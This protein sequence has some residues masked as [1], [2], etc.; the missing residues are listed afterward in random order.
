MSCYGDQAHCE[1]INCFGQ[2][3]IG[4]AGLEIRI[5]ALT[6]LKVIWTISFILYYGQY[7]AIY[8]KYDTRYHRSIDYSWPFHLC[9]TKANTKQQR[10]NRIQA[11]NQSISNFD[12]FI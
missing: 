12:D 4:Q 2:F 10:V 5:Q 3:E 7:K 11:F 8:C 9:F 6:H 1:N